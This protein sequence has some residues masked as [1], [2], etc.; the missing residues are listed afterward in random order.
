MRERIVRWLAIGT[1]A[2]AVGIA[3][4]GPA[5][6]GLPESFGNLENLKK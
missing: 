5:A 1:V 6:A 3:G 4:A 2:L